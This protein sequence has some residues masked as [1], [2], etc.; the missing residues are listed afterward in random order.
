MGSPEI[1]VA[2]GRPGARRAAER[3]RVGRPV[4]GAGAGAEAAEAEPGERERERAEAE[5]AETEPGERERERAEPEPE[6]PELERREA[7][8]EEPEE[9][10]AVAVRVK[11]PVFASWSRE[12]R[13]AAMPASTTWA[14]PWPLGVR[15]TTA[16]SPCCSAITSCLTE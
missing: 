5:A 6:E 8:A 1:L 15:R 16:I 14:R 3:E 10:E 2:L 13:A 7:E 11:A 12:R 4:L 9:A